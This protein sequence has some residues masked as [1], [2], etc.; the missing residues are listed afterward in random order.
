MEVL[1]RVVMDITLED[2]VAVV[3]PEVLEI[4]DLGEMVDLEE[5]VNHFLHLR[6]LWLNF[7]Y[8]HPTVLL[9]L[10]LLDQLVFMVVVE[11]LVIGPMVL[12]PLGV[13][14]E[15]GEVE[16]DLVEVDHHLLLYQVL[17][18]LAAEEVEQVQLLR[19]VEELVDLV[20]LSSDTL[21]K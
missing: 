1:V 11:V 18:I 10:L 2:G 19:E 21:H 12:H 20:L 16:M 14:V 6:H 15:E 4:M 13:L 3:V 17:Y 8:Q 5:M 9:L 7:F